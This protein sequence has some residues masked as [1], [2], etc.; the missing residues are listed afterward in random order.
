MKKKNFCKKHQKPKIV[1]DGQLICPDCLADKRIKKLKLNIDR[2]I[3]KM[4]KNKKS[5]ERGERGKKND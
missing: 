4:L 3:K 5:K 1:Q 2:N